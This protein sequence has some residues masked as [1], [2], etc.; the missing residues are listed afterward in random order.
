MRVE[1][2]K[3]ALAPLINRPFGEILTP[4]ELHDLR[5]DKGIV[6]KLLQKQ[7]GL[8]HNCD[9]CDFEDGE[10]KTNK[11]HPN[12]KPRETMFITQIADCLDLMLNGQAFEDTRLREKTRRMLYVP[13]CKTGAEANW[14]FVRFYDI[15]LSTPKY[16]A[17]AEQIRQD[18]YSIV[19]QLRQ[20]IE[21]SADG[22]IHT[23]NGDF[24]QVRS[25]DA[26]DKNG[27]YH[28]IKSKI[29]GRAVS[30]KNHAFYFKK[31]FML[32]IQEM[33]G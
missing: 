30:N 21:S 25:K 26:K 22:F 33:D 1:E 3:A 6:G 8:P 15:D 7:L 4:A 31:D 2:A 29:Y 14:H 27:L 24:V 20:Y 9:V 5:T 18:Y 10:L 19:G 17:V 11:C 12:C 13:I 28:P 23:S 32:H 16:A